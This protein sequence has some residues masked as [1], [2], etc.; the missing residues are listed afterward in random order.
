MWSV[1]RSGANELKALQ[2]KTWR[3]M[4]DLRYTG[5]GTGHGA[6]GTG[7][8]VRGTGHRARGTD[9]GTDIVWHRHIFVA[10]VKS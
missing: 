7:H 2:G 8:G 9:T 3:R 10:D 5:K 4:E 6:R 1:Y